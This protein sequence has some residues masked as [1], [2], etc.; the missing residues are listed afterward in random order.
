[1]PTPEPILACSNRPSSRFGN[2]CFYKDWTPTSHYYCWYCC[3][4]FNTVPVYLPVSRDPRTLVFHLCGNFC[5]WNCAKAYQFYREGFGEKGVSSYLS[6]FAFITSHRPRYCP[7]PLNRKHP[8][9]C[10]CI[11]IFKGVKLPPRKE[12]ID[13]FGGPLTIEQFRQ[14]S[15]TID[16]IEWVNRCFES[17]IN[18]S[19]HMNMNARIREFKYDFYLYSGIKTEEKKEQ[20]KEAISEPDILMANID[21]SFFY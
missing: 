8:Y 17:K 7:T 12:M 16:S 14:E 21:E 1:M 9:D 3:H 11:N 6:I 19:N 18:P 15:L 4:P 13:T 2:T 5:S 10:P 20:D